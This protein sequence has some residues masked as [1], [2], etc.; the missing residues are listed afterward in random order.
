MDKTE[1]G[2]AAGVCFF[3]FLILEL[4]PG[5]GNRRQLLSTAAQ[6]K[7]ESERPRNANPKSMVRGAVG[8][9]LGS[10]LGP[11]LVH[12]FYHAF[13]GPGDR[14]SP[15]IVYI[16]GGA[17]VG[18]LIFYSLRGVRGLFWGFMV[19]ISLGYVLGLALNYQTF[20]SVLIGLSLGILLSIFG[21]VMGGLTD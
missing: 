18:W 17:I 13:G 15:D 7:T 4:G 9:L 21:G 11:H 1:A 12:A 5:F 14:L 2:Q 10:Y 8:A 16:I 20:E 19:G 3:M 6:G